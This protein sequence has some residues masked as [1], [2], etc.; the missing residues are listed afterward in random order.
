MRVV[1]VYTGGAGFRSS[2]GAA[3]SKLQRP[4]ISLRGEWRGCA[5]ARAVRRSSVGRRPYTK[6]Y[7]NTF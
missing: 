1:V 7:A 2:R 5:A 3:G 6:L 4:I